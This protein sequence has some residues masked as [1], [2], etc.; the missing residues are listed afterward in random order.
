[1]KIRYKYRDFVTDDIRE[2]VRNN[3]LEENTEVIMGEYLPY[4]IFVSR[5]TFFKGLTIEVEGGFSIDRQKSRKGFLLEDI[6]KPSGK[7][8]AAACSG[9]IDSSSVTLNVR[10]D[11]VYT[12]YYSEPGFSEVPYAESVAKR[13]NA[14]HLV[15]EVTEEEY[16]QQLE[17]YLQTI[18]TPIAGLG[19]VAEMICLKRLMKHFPAT[20]VYFGNGGDEVFLGYFYNHMIRHLT[21]VADANHDYMENFRPSRRKF[22]YDN[23][24]IMLERLINR[25]GIF[26][27]GSPVLKR[28]AQYD[29]IIEKMLDININMTLPSLLHVNHMMC[30]AAGVTG[31][32]PLS[33]QD[34]ID[35]S[36]SFSELWED[37]PKKPL[38]DLCPQLPREITQRRDKQGFPT[39]VHKWAMLSEMI[40]E[41]VE[42]AGEEFTGINRRAWGLFMIDRWRKEFAV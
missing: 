22:I 38:V 28:V 23:I 13:V 18:C 31:H 20:D 36:L 39:P 7:V 14:I 42:R 9:G 30:K 1:M 3:R 21:D 27:N 40:R 16:I 41:S 29:D 35:R 24:D 37:R 17:D 11:Y 19:G 26:Y 2:I 5:E 25:G 4:Q 33:S 6:I 10:P 32:N 34:L 15:Y 8:M 12:G